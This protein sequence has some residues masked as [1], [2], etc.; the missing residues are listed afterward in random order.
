MGQFIDQV[1]IPAGYFRDFTQKNFRTADQDLGM[2]LDRYLPAD[3]DR[4]QDGENDGG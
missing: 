2:R 4:A 1:L 3:R